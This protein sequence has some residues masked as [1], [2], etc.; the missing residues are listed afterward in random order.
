M[1][2]GRN[3]YLLPPSPLTELRERLPDAEIEFD[4]GMT[5]AEAALAAR[6]ADV[7][8]VFADPRRGRGL[9][10]APTCRCRGA[11]TR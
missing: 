8:I 3:L 5:P 9:R 4:P 2:A 1:G 11:R 10:H 6:R 7:A